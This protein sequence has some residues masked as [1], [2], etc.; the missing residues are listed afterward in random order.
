MT[1]TACLEIVEGPGAGLKVPLRE[2]ILIGRDQEADL[3]LDNVHVSRWHARVSVG[4]G[5]VPT[6]EDLASSNGTFVN[7]TA[8]YGPTRMEDGDELLIGTTV[9]KLRAGA[10]VD[11][12]ATTVHAAINPAATAPPPTVPMAPI[13]PLPPSPLPSLAATPPSTDVASFHELEQLLDV[14]VRWRARTAPIAVL[15]LVALIVIVYLGAR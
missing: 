1:A 3:V 10:E 12:N 14:N 13:V 15:A 11:R 7:E 4:E 8:I 5:G 9:F 2:P 6:V